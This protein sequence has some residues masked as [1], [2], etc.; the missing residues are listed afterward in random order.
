MNFFKINLILLNEFTRAN[1]D[2]IDLITNKFNGNGLG[3]LN[4]NI[5]PFNRKRM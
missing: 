2:I 5:L 4:R 3:I 1:G